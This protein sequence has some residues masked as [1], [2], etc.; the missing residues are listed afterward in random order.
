M[1]GKLS[2][3]EA[4]KARAEKLEQF[5]NIIKRQ[6]KPDRVPLISNDGYWKLIDQ[7]IKFSVALHDYDVMYDAVCKY[8]ETYGFDVYMDY[9]SLNRVGFTEALGLE[10][11]MI[12]DDPPSL[13]INDKFSMAVEDYP[14]LISKGLAK[15]C[16]EDLL[17]R[18]YKYE[19]KEDAV[20]HLKEGVREMIKH[21]EY[22]GRI[23]QAMIYDYGTIGICAG[24]YQMPFEFFV[25]GLRGLKNTALDMRRH[26]EQ[27]L[28]ALEVIDQRTWSAFLSY[29]PD[30]QNDGTFIFDSYTCP[31]AYTLLS[32]KQFEKFYWPWMKKYFDFVEDH[33]QTSFIY[34]E[35][36]FM[37]KA[38]FLQDLKPGH[39]GVFLE[40]D[41]PLEVKKKLPNF[42]LMGGYPTTLLG[43][44][45]VEECLDKAKEMMDTV[46]DDG[47]W[48][49]SFDKLATYKSDCNRENLLAVLDYLKNVKL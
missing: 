21:T 13:Q 45:T 18:H 27:M 19:S 11:F 28:E 16:F 39:F 14:A 26:S 20:V 22:G 34:A 10:R 6:K 9:G 4:E 31:M 40:Q 35:G 38:D 30:I 5:N 7:D 12:D 44:G 2:P 48:I 41:D 23:Y 43:D 33:D 25:S 37:N 46:N 3:A 24:D 15:F 8:H 42:T 1:Y 17:C 49:F 29:A 32:P 47:N 36:S